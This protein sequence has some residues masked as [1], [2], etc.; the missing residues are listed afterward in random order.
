[1]K[2]NICVITILLWVSVSMAQPRLLIRCDDIGMCHSV[3]VAMEKLIETGIPFSASV[4]FCCPWIEEAVEILKAH[5]EVGVGVHLTLNSEWKHYKWGPISSRTVVPTLVDEQGYFW[6]SETLFQEQEINLEEVET[7]LKAQI[8]KAFS[9]GLRIDYLDYHMGTAVSTP[10]LRA[11]VE[12]LAREYEIGISGYFGE[13]YQTVWGIPPDRKLS[14]L[15]A[16][17]DE[18]Q[19]DRIHLIVIHLGME[20]PEMNALIDMNNPD[21]PYPVSRHRQAELD[22]ILSTV[23]QQV[24]AKKHIRLITYHDIVQTSKMINK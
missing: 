14:E 6:T 10:E 17:I 1:M 18:L 24:I 3:N 11:L 21:D 20:N 4:M 7:E 15:L 9:T 12:R 16:M 8:D 22:A 23:V 2:K 19:E 13:M 5:P